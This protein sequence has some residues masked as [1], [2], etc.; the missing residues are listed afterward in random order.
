MSAIAQEARVARQTLYNHYPDVES[1]VIAVIEQHGAL[2]EAQARQ[3]L[4]GHV[5]AAAKL[6]QLI[7]HSVTMGAHGHALVALESSLSSHAQQELGA[8]RGRTEEI[9]KEIL[10]EG[11][12][13]G[14][15][16]S[17]LDLEADAAFIREIVVS[18]VDPSG[19][20]DV[21][22][23]AGAAVRFVLAAVTASPG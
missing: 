13:E 9:V 23:L 12:V 19:I 14:V 6:E 2:G 15:F 3:L 21:S 11:V 8:H 1:I 7:R 4:A 20:H 16:R 5:G 18:S 17:D 22:W 10:Q